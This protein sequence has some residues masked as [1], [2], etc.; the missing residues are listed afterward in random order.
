MA[1]FSNDPFFQNNRRPSP[2]EVISDR[3]SHVGSVP[4]YT[5]PSDL[6]K[7]YCLLVEHT[8]GGNMQSWLDYINPSSIINN[9]ISIGSGNLTVHKGYRLP[10][11]THI[12][13]GHEVQYDHGFNWMDMAENAANI[14]TAG[15]YSGIKGFFGFAMNNFKY[16]TLQSPQFRSYAFEWKLHPKSPEESNAI[17]QIYMGLKSGMHPPRKAGKLAFEF[18]N[19]FWLGFYPNADYLVKFKPAVITSCQIDYQ[20]G[21]PVPTFYKNSNAPE[22]IIMRVTFLELEVWA[23]N[24]FINAGTTDPF[25]AASFYNQR[26]PQ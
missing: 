3:V 23:R 24:D 17:R 4:S 10:L 19:I 12:I 8:W 18:P 15:L 21:N 25:D 2:Q 14:G 13:D 20:G 1:N 16:V 26:D 11:P 9:A 6:P 5:F 22:S 7:Y